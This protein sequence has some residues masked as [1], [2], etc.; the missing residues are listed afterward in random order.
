MFF[1]LCVPSVHLLSFIFHTNHNQ[2]ACYSFC[3]CWPLTNNFI[4]FL[5]CPGASCSSWCC[6]LLLC[7]VA[8]A[9][10]AL[11]SVERR[12][13]VDTAGIGLPSH[14]FH[15]CCHCQ[16][17]SLAA[18]HRWDLVSSVADSQIG[19]HSCLHGFLAFVLS[20]ASGSWYTKHYQFHG[21][22]DRPSLLLLDLAS[23]S[24][25]DWN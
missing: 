3:S 15:L 4:F 14:R 13:V 12:I 2:Y 23:A 18:A 9:T 20:I 17:R 22:P 5:A 8:P 11:D 24:W 16:F 19:K 1:L 6:L 7:H 10:L 25:E 21:S